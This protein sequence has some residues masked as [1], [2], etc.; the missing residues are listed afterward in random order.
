MKF[1]PHSF[2]ILYEKKQ[3]NAQHKKCTNSN[4]QSSSRK[5]FGKSWKKFWAYMIG[6]ESMT[7]QEKATFVQCPLQPCVNS[8]LGGQIVFLHRS[9]PLQALCEQ[10]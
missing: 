2:C 8:V 10:R 1:L 9:F 5:L 7:T 6:G 3:E 4:F